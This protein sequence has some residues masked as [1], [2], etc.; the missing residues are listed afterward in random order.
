MYMVFRR[1]NV[2]LAIKFDSLSYMKNIYTQ[3]LTN[4]I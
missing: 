3:G 4:A 2:R 1:V